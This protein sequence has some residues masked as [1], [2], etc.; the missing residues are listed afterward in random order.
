METTIFFAP[1]SERF[2]VWGSY[3]EDGEG[4]M[5]GGRILLTSRPGDWARADWL[6]VIHSPWACLWTNI[7]RERRI[8]ILTEPPGVTVYPPWYLEQ[9][10][11]VAS[12]YPIPGYGGRLVL[13]NSCIGWFAG[14]RF[15]SSRDVLAYPPP[16]KPRTLSMVTSLK[17]RLP[18][19]KKRLALMR[20]AKR[21]FG[22]AF[23][24]FGAGF[25]P[26]EDKLDAIAPYKYHLAVENSRLPNYWTEKL[27]DPWIG[28]ALPIYCGDPTIL[29]QVPDPRGLELIDAA[30]IPGSIE[31]I[32]GILETDPYESRLEAIS[33]CRRWAIQRANPYERACEIVET[34]PASTQAAPRL[35]RPELLRVLLK[36]RK[37]LAYRALRVSLGQRA[38]DRA[39][40]AWCRGLGRLWGS[41]PEG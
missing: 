1:S 11:A 4:A 3:P 7:P 5:R 14:V 19:R 9:F 40:L 17:G 2:G 27:A 15:R 10:G 23:D 41:A 28:W 12:P 36:D 32:R 35:Q 26:V 6:L 21:A 13:G 25:A 31:R 30:D 33:K 8:L 34:A 37:G 38:A 22:D 39:L 29:D 24:T 16:R 20:A 18:Y